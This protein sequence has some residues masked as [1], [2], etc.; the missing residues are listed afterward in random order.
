M[1]N[2]T[3]KRI[4]V[5]I[6]KDLWMW[7]KDAGWTCIYIYT[8]WLYHPECKQPAE[9]ESKLWVLVVVDANKLYL[10]W[11]NT[12]PQNTVRGYIFKS[13]GLCLNIQ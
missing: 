12:L 7:M 9:S 10:S 5:L 1:V 2:E 11:I 6:D 4:L 13:T 8:F 3:Q